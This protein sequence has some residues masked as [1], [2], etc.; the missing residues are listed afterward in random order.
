MIPAVLFLCFYIDKFS[1]RGLV[2]IN[3]FLIKEE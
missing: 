1:F 2:E 3:M